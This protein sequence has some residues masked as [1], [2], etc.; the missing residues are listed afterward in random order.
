MAQVAERVRTIVNNTMDSAQ[1]NL[2][3]VEDEAQRVLHSLME[4]LKASQAEAK[5]VIDEWTGTVNEAAR[6][7]ETIRKDVLERL[8]VAAEDEVK[9][10][11]SQLDELR[12]SIVALQSGLEDLGRKIRADV[13]REVKA[14]ADDVKK[15][16]SE[17]QQKKSHD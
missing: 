13:R 3:V 16:R 14:V 1:K 5:R 12:A 9:A 7:S 6:K 8:G 17:L 10:A 2:H 11:R 15:L 4:H